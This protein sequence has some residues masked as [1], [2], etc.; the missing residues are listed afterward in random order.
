MSH[1]IFLRGENDALS[2]YLEILVT[3]M[4]MY[5]QN[6][7]FQMYVTAHSDE[8]G[9]GHDPYQFHDNP[10]QIFRVPTLG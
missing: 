3:Y 4:M 5:L 9:L 2:F 6:P 8:G 1:I 10:S 7:N